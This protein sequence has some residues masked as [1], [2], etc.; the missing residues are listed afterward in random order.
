[1][2]VEGGGKEENF[3]CNGEV[4]GSNWKTMPGD[5]PRDKGFSPRKKEGSNPEG[6]TKDPHQ[7]GV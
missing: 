7:G 1:M 2:A 6:K 4:G 3:C 5:E